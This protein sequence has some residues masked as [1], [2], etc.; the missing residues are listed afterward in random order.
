[1]TIQ[2][3]LL[4][5]KFRDRCQMI[6][7]FAFSSNQFGS[8]IKFCSFKFKNFKELSL[9]LRFAFTKK[10]N[11]KNFLEPNSKMIYIVFKMKII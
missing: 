6:C 4:N 3:V 1:M 2:K 9:S 10:Y 5:S 8:P 7:Q 11:K